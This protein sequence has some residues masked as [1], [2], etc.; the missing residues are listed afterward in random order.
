[1]EALAKVSPI[2][3]DCHLMMENPDRWSKLGLQTPV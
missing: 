3:L 2:P 1:V